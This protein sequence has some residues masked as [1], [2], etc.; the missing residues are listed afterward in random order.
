[1]KTL[2]NLA[3]LNESLIFIDDSTGEE[4]KLDDYNEFFLQDEPKQLIFA[5]LDNS[6]T[7]V[8]LFWLLIKSNHAIALLPP[9]LSISLK[10]DLEKL[11]KPK[12]IFDLLRSEILDYKKIK[13]SVFLF[14]QRESENS[15]EIHENIKLLLNTS[16]TTGSPKFVKLSE[17][18]L[19]SN[20]RS[21]SQYLPLD[22]DDV[23]PL[24]LPIYYSYGLSILTSNSICGGKIVCTNDDLLK[25]SFWENFSKYGYTSFAGV[26][27]V[28]EMLDRIGFT[29]KKYTSLKYFTQA[30]GKLPD[31]LVKKYA[32]Y[33]IQNGNKFFVMYGQ[34]EATARMS[35]LSPEFTLMKLGSI[36]QAIPNGK[37]KIEPETN[38]LI[39]FGP[40]IYGGYVESLSDLSSF[41]Q[42]EYLQTGDTAM[43]DVDGFY[44]ITGRLKRF[45]KIFGNR[46]NL[47]EVEQLIAKSFQKHVK[48]IGNKD[49]ELLVF[50]SEENFEIEPIL[51][52]L[53][54]E[55]KIHISVIKIRYIT[56]FPLT[57]NGK[58]DYNKLLNIYES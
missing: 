25:K 47:D 41:K 22:K 29:K 6:V 48:C 27:F 8:L 58:I 24:N 31:H 57:N 4:Y 21:I 55:L 32:E 15:Y 11:Y 49:K 12:W 44:Y 36:G 42:Q 17:E 51:S 30:G 28:Y 19:I 50:H 2:Y 10:L 14:F 34:T 23:T 35:Y 33:S 7:S 46:V 56:E 45:V 3:L 54:S 40:N 38:E 20:A 1:M 18:N 39:Y 9:N 13:N 5:Y 26:P 52:Y 43:V 16:G 37:F 53:T